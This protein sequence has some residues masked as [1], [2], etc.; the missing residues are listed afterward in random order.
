LKKLILGL[1]IIGSGAWAEFEVKMNIKGLYKDTFEKLSRD[2]QNYIYDNMDKIQSITEATLKKETLNLKKEKF[3]S[4]RNVVEMIV[5]KDG[6]VKE[7]TFLSK[8]SERRF[9]NITKK[10]LEEAVKSYPKQNEPTPIRMIM[11][12]ENG[13]AKPFISEKEKKEKER[14]SNMLQRGTTRFEH[15][16]SQQVREF[17]TSRDGFINA[18]VNPNSCAQISLLTETNQKVNVGLAMMFIHT[19]IN[20]EVPKGRYKL[21]VQTRETCNVN[22]QYP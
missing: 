9:D 18:N 16:M 8:S 6:S 1:L 21:L 22:I 12:Y 14:Y 15:S 20:V 5:E 19:A 4:D 17:E 7:I 13:N 11:I 2:Q 10:V 3:I